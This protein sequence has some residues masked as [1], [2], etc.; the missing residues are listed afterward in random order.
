MLLQSAGH[1]THAHLRHAA[2]VDAPAQEQGLLLLLLAAASSS[3]MAAA[4]VC[5]HR[6]HVG[7][8]VVE[9]RRDGIQVPQRE[10]VPLF[11]CDQQP[12]RRCC[13]LCG[14][15]TAWGLLALLALLPAHELCCGAQERVCELL[16]INHVGGQPQRRLRQQ[17]QV[18]GLP[19]PHV[20]LRLLRL[21]VLLPAIVLLA[22]GWL[23]HDCGVQQLQHRSRLRHVL[24][25]RRA[26]KVRAHRLLLLLLLLLCAAASCI[27][28][29]TVLVRC[30]AAGQRQH[31]RAR[32]C[33]EHGAGARARGRQAGDADARAKLQHHAA[34]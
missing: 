4:A 11:D 27:P 12:R 21:P 26:A 6:L 18:L 7:Q 14:S 15:C 19:R 8:E 17:L 25:R 34:S 22:V 32:V 23:L 3:C 29:A 24:Q 9:R 30:V 16:R 5:P 13:R 31:A 1:S 20:V 28:R 10:V 33:E 2:D